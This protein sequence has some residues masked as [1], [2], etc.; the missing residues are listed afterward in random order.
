VVTKK[1]FNRRQ[2]GAVMEVCHL[3]A[4]AR[5]PKSNLQTGLE[6]R[7]HIPGFRHKDMASDMLRLSRKQFKGGIRL[8]EQIGQAVN[9]LRKT[10]HMITG[11]KRTPAWQ[12]QAYVR[13]SFAGIPA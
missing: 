7:R 3:I 10:I 4:A 13:S 12:G 8:L 9:G 2:A 11:Y 1:E 5:K 6:V